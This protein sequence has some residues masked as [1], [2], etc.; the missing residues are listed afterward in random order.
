MS[1]AVSQRTPGDPGDGQAVDHG[2][3][4]KH[5][6]HAPL[7]ARQLRRGVRR[8]GWLNGAAWPPSRP[9]LGQPDAT[10]GSAIGQRQ[11]SGTVPRSPAPWPDT[12]GPSP[13]PCRAPAL[14]PRPASPSDR[15]RPD[16]PLNDLPHS[17]ALYV[18]DSQGRPGGQ[19]SA[20]GRSQRDNHVDLCRPLPSAAL[21]VPGWLRHGRW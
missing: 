20:A 2:P 12:P 3:L 1:P 6:A 18:G 8:R 17:S 14:R 7:D 10:V 19:R 5:G 15:R 13:Q 4:A 16:R 11:P 21:R 9:A